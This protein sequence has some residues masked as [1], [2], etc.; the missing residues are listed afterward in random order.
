MIFEW[1]SWYISIVSG[2]GWVALIL[3]VSVIFGDSMKPI[4]KGCGQS[5]SFGMGASQPSSHP[6]SA[7]FLTPEFE[8]LLSCNIEDI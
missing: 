7:M 5:G 6:N 4:M 2:L 1:D 3:C 8:D